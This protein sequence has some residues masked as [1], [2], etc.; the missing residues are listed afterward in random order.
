MEQDSRMPRGGKRGET[1]PEVGDRVRVKFGDQW[2]EGVVTRVEGGE[3]WVE[4]PLEDGEGMEEC[5][6]PVSP[7]T[8]FFEVLATAREVAAVDKFVEVA[9]GVPPADA[10]L[11]IRRAGGSADD[12]LNL[13]WQEQEV[14]AREPAAA[15]A[16]GSAAAGS[17]AAAAAGP[18]AAAAGSAAAAAWR[19]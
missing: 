14:A 11:Y 16:A 13:Y 8:N 1:P 10:L 5:S 4:Y 15:G 9:G 19:R 7:A 17:V 3:F 6:D 2:E 12:A 18:A